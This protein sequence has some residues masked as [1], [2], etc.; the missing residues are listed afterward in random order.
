M[1]ADPLQ[2]RKRPQVGFWL[3]VMCGVF[4][5][6]HPVWLYESDNERCDC[7]ADHTYVGCVRCG[8]AID[9][10]VWLR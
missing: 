9:V 1:N 10:R 2:P 6:S 5:H 8:V 4:G 3:S 7:G